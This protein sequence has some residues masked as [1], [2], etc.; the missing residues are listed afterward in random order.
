MRMS[1]TKLEASSIA[2][3][4]AKNLGIEGKKEID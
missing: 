4:L 1:K 2:S 3:S